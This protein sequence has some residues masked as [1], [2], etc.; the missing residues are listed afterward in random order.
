MPLCFYNYFTKEKRSF[1]LFIYVLFVLT[2]SKIKLK[3]KM[4]GATEI[5]Q[6]VR[7]SYTGLEVSIHANKGGTQ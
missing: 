6:T 3:Y 7:D 1:T 2:A 5:I 4:E